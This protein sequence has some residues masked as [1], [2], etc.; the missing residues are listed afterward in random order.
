MKED[1]PQ[2]HHSNP[3]KSIYYRHH[4]SLDNI[5]S[6]TPQKEKLLPRAQEWVLHVAGPS[7]CSLPT[8]SLGLKRTTI[9]DDTQVVKVWYQEAVSALLRFWGRQWTMVRNEAHFTGN[10][11]HMNG[12]RCW[13]SKGKTIFHCGVA[14]PMGQMTDPAQFAGPMRTSQ[15]GCPN[16]GMKG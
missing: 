3:S 6:T 10:F 8:Q 13:A 16:W 11:L 9:L 12:L 14:A 4:H 15:K 5:T 1:W 7:H 2:D